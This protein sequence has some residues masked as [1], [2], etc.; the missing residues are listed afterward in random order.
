MYEVLMYDKNSSFLG[1]ISWKRAI[2]LVVKDKAQ[3]VKNT[4]IKV[5][6]DWFVPLIIKLTA[7]IK[8]LWKIGVNW[9]KKNIHLRDNYVCQYCGKEL[10]DKTA[11]VDHIVPKVKGGKST[12]VNTVTSCF[13]CNNRKA[14][15]SL[16]KSGLRLKKKPQKPSIAFFNQKK[17]QTVLQRYENL[18]Y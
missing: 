16:E 12:W 18:I 1:T 8:N 5:H 2:I 6:Q 13:S 9:S 14:N 7:P 10:T 15:L 4:T 11:T 17:Q 3:I